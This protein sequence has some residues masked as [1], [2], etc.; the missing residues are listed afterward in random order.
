M[1]TELSIHHEA[2]EG[3]ER[4]MAGLEKRGKFNQV[5]SS[6]V[7]FVTFVVIAAGQS[8]NSVRHCASLPETVFE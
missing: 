7:I 4:W 1:R 5:F 8:I 6:F 2:H 3:Q